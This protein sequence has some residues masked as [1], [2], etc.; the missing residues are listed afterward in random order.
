MIYKVWYLKNDRF[1]V[2]NSNNLFTVLGFLKSYKEKNNLEKIKYINDSE[3][4]QPLIDKIS[5]IKIEYS[6]IYSLVINDL[7]NEIL[8]E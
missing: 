4:F 6:T 5:M 1:I 8:E 3:Y 2:K 7:Y